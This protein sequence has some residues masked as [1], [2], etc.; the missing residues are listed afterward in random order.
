MMPSLSAR[1]EHANRLYWKLEEVE[2]LD[3]VTSVYQS[4]RFIAQY[5]SCKFDALI[6]WEI[7]GRVSVGT[8]RGNS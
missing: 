3:E 8:G 4:Q 5:R 2:D 7:Y 6:G 1:R